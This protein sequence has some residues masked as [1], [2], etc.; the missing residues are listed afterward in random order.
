MN[1]LVEAFASEIVE[2]VAEKLTLVPTEHQQ[3]A[4][5]GIKSGFCAEALRRWPELA[6]EEIAAAAERF[7]RAVGERARDI[8]AASSNRTGT[9]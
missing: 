4:L 2:G 5:R 8:G 6:G 1:A 3:A 9:A 7:A